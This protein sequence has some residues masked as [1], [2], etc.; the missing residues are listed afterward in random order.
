MS[1][2]PAS[3]SLDVQGA[4]INKEQCVQRTAAA[5]LAGNVSSGP[6]SQHGATMNPHNILGTGP[7]RI[8]TG[9]MKTCS[10]CGS[11]K[12]MCEFGPKKGSRDGKDCYCRIC[13]TLRR[14]YSIPV[15]SPCSGPILNYSEVK[16]DQRL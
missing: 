7:E 14:R 1:V 11:T 5:K 12:D 8:P 2:G 13:S 10:L 4:E 15:R 3:F 9:Q 6:S 16:N